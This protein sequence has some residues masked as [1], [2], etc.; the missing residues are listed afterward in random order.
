MKSL[1]LP[2][3]VFSLFLLLFSTN[4]TFAQQSSS[5]KCQHNACFTVQYSYPKGSISLA[6][7][8]TYRYWGFRVYT[9]A[10]YGDPNDWEAPKALVLHYHRSLDRSDFIDNSKDTLEDNPNVS[11][12]AISKPLEEINNLYVPVKEGDRYS[13]FYAPRSEKLTLR[14]ND[15]PIGTV[16]GKKFA[17]A[18]FGIWISDY[19]VGSSFTERLLGR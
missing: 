4:Q 19:S 15:E 5:E 3:I 11:I 12:E 7:L 1:K 13:I 9:A 6:G 16:T 10:F 8:S 14:Y 2:Y 18:Y 17:Q